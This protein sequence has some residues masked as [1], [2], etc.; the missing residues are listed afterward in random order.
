MRTDWLNRASLI[1]ARTQVIN[2]C[3]EAN[4]HKSP[5]CH[6]APLPCLPSL[7]AA[8]DLDTVCMHAAVAMH[9]H[10]ILFPLTSAL[11][12][13]VPGSR[14]DHLSFSRAVSVTLTSV[15]RQAFTHIAC[16]GRGSSRATQAQGSPEAAPPACRC[17]AAAALCPL[18]CLPVSRCQRLA[19]VKTATGEYGLQDQP[20]RYE[21]PAE[22][23][24]SP[25]SGLKLCQ[26][27]LRCL[28]R[29]RIGG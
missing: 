18:H 2:R 26:L 10:P 8:L 3:T 17:A 6:G 25:G 12:M 24:G 27:A 13:H 11:C 14:S 1:T 15:A 21:T 9:L 4:K 29:L 7:P 28:Q 22:L 19:G 5:I 16:I 23:G 20:Y